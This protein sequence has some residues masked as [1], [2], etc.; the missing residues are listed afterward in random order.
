MTKNFIIH[1]TINFFQILLEKGYKINT[2]FKTLYSVRNEGKHFKLKKRR[3]EIF[4]RSSEA[5]PNI[6]IIS[7]QSRVIAGPLGWW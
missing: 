7:V 4:C 3:T 6:M 2:I 1:K 5:A